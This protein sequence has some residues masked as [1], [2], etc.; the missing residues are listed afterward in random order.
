PLTSSGKIN[1]KALPEVD[2]ASLE[3]ERVY[4]EPTTPK[5]K[6]LCRILET[7]FDV[8]Q[9]GITDDFFNDLGGDSLKV[10]EFV[11]ES[12]S[13]GIYFA[14][15]NV[16]DY[17]TVETLCEFIENGDKLTL[18]FADYDYE[19]VNKALGR[20]TLEQL[21][22]PEER[23]IGNILLAGATGYL[24]IHVLDDFLTHDSG[25]AYCL[26]RGDNLKD[27]KQRFK[28]LLEFYFGEKYVGSERIVVICADLQRDF[29]GLSKEQ[30]SELL[31]KVDTVIN[32]AASVKHYGSYKYFYEANVETAKRLIE[33]TKQAQAVLVHTSTLSVSGNS[34]ADDFD[35]YVSETEKHFFESS[36]YIGQ[37]LENVYVRSKF[38]AEISVLE[39]IADG[40][41]AQIM[42]MGNLTNRF[43]DGKFQKNYESNAFLQRLRAVM[44]LK[45]VP[46]Y[47]MSLY[48]EFTP[49]DEA[50]NAVM[51][52]ARHF[53][54]DYNVFHI[55]STKVVYLDRLLE[56]MNRL[57]VPVKAVSEAEFTATLRDTMKQTQ[58][59]HIFEAFIGDMDENEHLNYD[60]N[61]RIENDFTVEYLRKLGFEWNDIDFEYIRKYVEYLKTI[62]YLEG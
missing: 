56:Y 7:V 3:T 39:A 45:V 41:P 38:E 55:N 6:A 48:S 17:P 12:H 16:F 59:K 32:C 36:L 19:K 31:A 43:C 1:R 37:S 47:L 46:D 62:G 14:L 4:V 52:I 10:I 40:L 25:T 58:S 28:Q 13:E 20:N 27:S 9:V 24:G 51:T 21:S 33:F 44:N 15:Q 30:Y 53:T 8:G 23:E 26:V 35:G 61:I 60:S 54:P 42:R 29:F 50:A 22:A 34:F 49:I 5:Q 57:G 2:F 11:S 18:D